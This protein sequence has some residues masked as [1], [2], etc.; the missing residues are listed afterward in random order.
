[1]LTSLHLWRHQGK[2]TVLSMASRVLAECMVAKQHL[3][4]LWTHLS[5]YFG[6]GRSE[7]IFLSVLT[8]QTL[9]LS[10]I[11]D[12]LTVYDLCF[13]FN[14]LKSC[15]L[16]WALQ[17]VKLRVP[18]EFGNKEMSEFSF[19]IKSSSSFPPF[20]FSLLSLCAC[21]SVSFLCLCLRVCL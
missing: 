16:C 12:S 13:L 19:N 1:M 17:K 9:C 6:S 8:S 15:L 18:S 10:W 2:R 7:E 4:E 3:C 11:T 14:S 5:L 20:L 21:L